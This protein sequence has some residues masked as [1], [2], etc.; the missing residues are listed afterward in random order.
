MG[1]TTFHRD[2]EDAVCCR[3]ETEAVV[4]MAVD[5]GSLGYVLFFMLYVVE[6]IATTTSS[7]IDLHR[8][9]GI[10]HPGLPSGTTFASDAARFQGD[11]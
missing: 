7:C 3:A 9:P 4:L 5:R 11:L 10:A 8:V 1:V 2:F 6:I